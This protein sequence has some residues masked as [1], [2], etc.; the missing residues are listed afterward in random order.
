[1]FPKDYY[2]LHIVPI[3]SQFKEGLCCQC[4]IL[5]TQAQGNKAYNLILNAVFLW[6][7]HGNSGNHINS[8]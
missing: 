8:Y 6:T 2:N 3:K 1:M 7:S 4:V 5:R